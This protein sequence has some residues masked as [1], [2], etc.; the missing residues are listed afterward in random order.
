MAPRVPPNTELFPCAIK[1]P[2]RHGKHLKIKKS[3]WIE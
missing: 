2:P 1:D 3:S